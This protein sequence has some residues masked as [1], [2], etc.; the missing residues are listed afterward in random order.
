MDPKAVSRYSR[1]LFN[2]ADE[3]RQLDAVEKDLAQARK[4]VGQYPEIS[5][6]VL[7][8]TIS[9]AEKEDFI[10]KVMPADLS[11]LVIDFVKVLVKKRRFQELSFIQ[12]A[13]HRLYE[14]KRGIQEVK[15]VSAIP[16]TGAVQDK[17]VQA[18]K[19]KFQCE[20]RLLPE[21]DPGILGGFILRFDGT[22]IN[23]SYKNRLEELRQ[24]L[25]A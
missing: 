25:M 15:V 17:L 12:E 11:R 14:K 13:F 18:L 7:N 6:L 24:R 1:A 8:S 20:V 22:E 3:R 23:G 2:L 9:R 10:E 21:T 5:H 16:L 19:R 4:L